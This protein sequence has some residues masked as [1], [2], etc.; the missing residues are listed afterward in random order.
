LP[1]CSQLTPAHPAVHSSRRYNERTET[2]LG[3]LSWG[4]NLYTYAPDGRTDPYSLSPPTTPGSSA[5]G[6]GRGGAALESGLDNGPM[7]SDSFNSTGR[8]VLD[9][10]D[11]GYGAL[12]PPPLPLATR[13]P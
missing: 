10:Y 6:G 2:P 11:A 4:S 5:T 8:N 13:R 7:Y 9:Q 1:S 3:M 12:S